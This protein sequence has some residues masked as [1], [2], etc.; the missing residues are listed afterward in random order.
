MIVKQV[1]NFG[2]G[3][4]DLR[5]G[6]NILA[7]A[8]CSTMGPE[9][10]PAIIESESA[11]GGLMISK[12]GVTVARNIFLENPIENM[13]V[14]IMKQAADRTATVAGDGTTTSICLTRAILEEA[15]DQIGEDNNKT[16]VIRNIVKIS[17][18][19]DKNL[20]KDSKKISGRKLLDVATISANNDAKTG[21]L[22][23]DAY[24]KASL[25]TV[26]K[27]MTT[28]SHYEV[29]EGIKI[30]RGFSS[31]F[32]ITDHK[33]NE[34]ILENAY[35][36]I[37]D[38]E[39][40]TLES[41]E[42]VLA[43]CVQNNKPLF[44]VG[45]L[46]PAVLNTLNM[47]V[48][49]K[50]IKFGNCIPPAMGY[51]KEELLTDLAIALGAKYYSERT[52]DIL[53]SIS[54]DGLGKAK[55]VIISQ[56]NTVIIRDEYNE[57]SNLELDDHIKQLKESI[58]LQSNTQAIDFLNE[59]I[60]NISGGIGVIYV[61]AE[62]DI[63]QKELYDRVE[64]AVLAVR[65]SLEEGILPGGGIGLINACENLTLEGNEDYETAL[66]IM[67]KALEYP[68][69]QILENAGIKSDDIVHELAT[70]AK[71]YGYNVKT[72]E[73]GDMIKMGIIDPA[74]VTKSALKNAVSVATT[75]LSTSTI[76][77][78]IRA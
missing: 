60:A 19:I 7:D 40:N 63:E 66:D 17:K 61:G 37:T 64:D 18:E 71:G 47:N 12:D 77:S 13:A 21:K 59:R 49:Q 3:Q 70:L 68:F 74:K 31:K 53:T 46:A 36:L 51:R 39:I 23:A 50:R 24:S 78:N 6:I 1:K 75:I 4:A 43:F 2:S 73:L 58:E 72:R 57:E 29:I 42:P 52:G 48:I 11:I 54:V 9:G 45:E 16:E 15:Y 30:N 28:E 14:Q 25:V 10:R 8:V 20:T 56:E 76:I 67:L 62:T 26:E 35:V 38:Q 32:F 22:I 34:A 27:S 55:K 65:A 69:H 44:I 41:I 33:K 5:K